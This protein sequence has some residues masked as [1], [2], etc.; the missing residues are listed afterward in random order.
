[1]GETLIERVGLTFVRFGNPPTQA[2]GITLDD[3]LAA[4]RRTAIDDDIFDVL[5]N[6]DSN[7]ERMVASRK[8]AWL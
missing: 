8:L 7:T 5:D 3:L 2:A 1:M 6:P 4:V